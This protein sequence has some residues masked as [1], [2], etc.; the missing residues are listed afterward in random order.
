MCVCIRVC[1]D[2]QLEKQLDVLGVDGGVHSQYSQ[3]NSTR[4]AAHPQPSFDLLASPSRSLTDCPGRSCRCGV[5]VV[6]RLYRSGVA[7]RS[8]CASCSNWSCLLSMCHRCL[9]L[10]TQPVRPSID[11]SRVRARRSAV[12]ASLAKLQQQKEQRAH[13]RKAER[14]P[15]D[16][17]AVAAAA[18]GEESEL[19]CSQL[20]Q[21]DLS[22]P[23]RSSSTGSFGPA[24]EAA[25]ASSD[26]DSGGVA[27]EQLSNEAP[28]AAELLEWREEAVLRSL[29]WVGQFVHRSRECDF[30]SNGGDIIF[31]YRF[32]VD[33][34]SGRVKQAADQAL[35][36]ML[37]K[38]PEHK[39]TRV[40]AHTYSHAT[41]HRNRCSSPSSSTR[42]AHSRHSCSPPDIPN[43]RLAD[44]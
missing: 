6:P 16:E 13:K 3:P 42:L 32:L 20:S 12:T 43:P 40:A 25:A 37:S 34:C 27:V 15:H 44:V 33:R 24:S 29:S 31:L 8:V 11:W 9:R 41:L 30:T 36:V 23:S 26:G 14:D 1:V 38:W 7:T 21:S 2:G 4:S 28:S 10:T 5:C 19:E 17:T 22:Q 18:G 35:T 39:H